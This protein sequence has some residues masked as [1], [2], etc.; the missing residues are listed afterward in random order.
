MARKIDLVDRKVIYLLAS[1]NSMLKKR[2]LFKLVYKLQEKGVKFGISFVVNKNEKFYFSEELDKRIE[3]L[4]RLGYLEK[5]LI[6]ERKFYEGSYI[7]AII[8]KNK[9]FKIFSNPKFSKKDKEIIDK[10]VNKLKQ[11]FYI[12]NT[13]KTLNLAKEKSKRR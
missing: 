7:E 13:S 1:I 3:K 5:I 12:S 11:R 6:L 4:A 10:F 9:V 2:T 8:P